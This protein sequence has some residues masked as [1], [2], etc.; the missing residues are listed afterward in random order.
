LAAWKPRLHFLVWLLAAAALLYGGGFVLFAATLPL[1]PA[2]LDHPDAIVALT[3]GGARLNAAVALF[4]KGVGKRL[5][6]SGVNTNTTRAELKK[7]VHGGPRFDC[8]ADLGFA[9]ADTH[10]N[11]AEAAAW[12]AEHHF[13]RLVIVTASYHMPRSLAEFAAE[14]PGVTLEPWPVEPDG[15]NLHAWWRDPHALRLLQG[16]Y[17]KYLASLV[18]THFATDGERKLLDHSLVRGEVPGQSKGGA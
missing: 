5:L 15:I 17:A 4:E 16:E 18:L 7:L 13:H 8:C 1:K 10:G 2:R 14:M 6:I 9:A 12:A 3:G 11:A